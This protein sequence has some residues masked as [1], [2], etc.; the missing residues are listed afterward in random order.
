MNAHEPWDPSRAAALIRD[1]LQESRAF[2]GAET[3]AQSALLPALH[4]LQHAFGHVPPAAWSLLAEEL[5]ISKAEVRGV[6]SFYD[7]FEQE[8]PRGTRLALCR[9]EACQARGSE[10]LA[11]RL[12]ADPPAGVAVR[13]A[14]CLGNCALGP[15]ALVDGERLM[16]R[17]TA[18]RL[19]AL[20]AELRGETP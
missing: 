5:G 19:D 2:A 4:A 15:N 13:E 16:G 14:Y 9:A 20:I 18:A 6:M 11:A 7:D 17:L 12:Q 10:A 3:P 1:A 8:P